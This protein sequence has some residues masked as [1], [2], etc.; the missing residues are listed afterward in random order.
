M[1]LK[2][3][4]SSGTSETQTTFFQVFGAYHYIH[5]AV[6]GGVNVVAVNNSWGG[7]NY[8]TIYDKLL[9]LVGEEG[10]ISYLAA[11]NNGANNERTRTCPANS[12]SDFAVSVGAAG[13]EGSRA[14]F[15]NYEK[16]SVDVF[17]PA[18]RCFPPLQ[19]TYM[20]PGCM[21]QKS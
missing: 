12:E 15:S 13:I 20:P 14:I 3:F 19:V 10:V 16:T 5:K 8:S 4:S 21:T 9:D 17:G 6:Q 11:S 18:C 2:T 1:A 7:P